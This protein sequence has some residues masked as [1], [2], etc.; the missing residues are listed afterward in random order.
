MTDDMPGAP[1][2]YQPPTQPIQ[3][4]AYQPP[5]PPYQA[6][7]PYQSP[8]GPYETPSASPYQPPPPYQHPYANQ[9]WP[10]QPQNPGTN[11][12]AIAALVLGIVWVYW[13]GSILA[14][15]FGHVALGQIKRTG[16]SGQG[17]AV[18]GLV[19]GYIG[20]AV[21]ALM[22]AIGVAASA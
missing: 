5:P 9:Y 7:S 13:I 22:V 1:P 3:P 4:P 17:M 14:V 6:S 18:A 8:P 12:L 16:Q 11:G 15:I 2:P 19:L 21:F 10:V 20:I